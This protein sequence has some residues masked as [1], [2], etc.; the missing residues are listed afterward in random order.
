MN[1]PN[2]KQV[3]AMVN[4]KGNPSWVEFV[5]WLEESLESQSLSVNHASGENTIKMQGR[6][7]EIEEILKHIESCFTYSDNLRRK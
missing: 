7:L 3:R 2:E 5:E 1:K 4:L 6:N